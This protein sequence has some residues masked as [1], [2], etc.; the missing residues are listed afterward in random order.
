MNRA[1]R[2]VGALSWLILLI[3][4]AGF[5]LLVFLAPAEQTLGEVIRYVY[6]H[7]ALTKAGLWGFYL[8][9][10]LGLLVLISGHRKL[11]AWTQI[12][13]WVALALFV[14]GGIVSV[15]AGYASWGGFP[16]DEPRNRTM[17]SVIA[18]AVVVLILNYWL[19]WTRVRGFL[20]MVLALFAAWIIPNTPLILHPGNAGGNSPSATI[21]WVFILLPVIA[22]FIGAWLVWVIGRQ[23]DNAP[24]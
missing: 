9:G 24:N 23:L 11:Q 6:I 14:A 22:F 2:N 20:S 12:V 16:L 19:P 13:T 5:L 4:I 18:L 17:F 1:I 10:L 3:L 21:R 15:F 7:V 8:A